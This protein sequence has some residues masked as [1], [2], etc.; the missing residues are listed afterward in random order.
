MLS[1]LDMLH[2]SARSRVF[3]T[4][5]KAAA[6]HKQELAI[7]CERAKERIRIDGRPCV[8][9]YIPWDTVLS[10]HIGIVTMEAVA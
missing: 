10:P 1:R 2:L 3:R 9:F 4:V 6:R 8:K 7:E 5:M